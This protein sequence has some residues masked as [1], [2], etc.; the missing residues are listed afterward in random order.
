MS[1]STGALTVSALAV[2]R[3]M[4]GIRAGQHPLRGE[5]T[6]RRGPRAAANSGLLVR[7]GGRVATVEQLRQLVL[8]GTVRNACKDLRHAE[9]AESVGRTSSPGANGRPVRWD[10]W[11]LTTAGLAAAASEL[12]RPVPEMGGTARDAAKAGA[13]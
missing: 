12:G 6:R 2:E 11:N 1:D 13:P 7:A 10:L 9:L 5:E 8:P 3:E 4:N